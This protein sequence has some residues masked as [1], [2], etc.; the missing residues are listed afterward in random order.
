VRNFSV[1]AALFAVVLPGT[2][3]AAD[4]V[5]GGDAVMVSGTIALHSPVPDK[6]ALGYT[7]ITFDKPVCIKDAQGKD[8]PEEKAGS[9]AIVGSDLKLK[10]GQH[11]SLHGVLSLRVGDPQPPEKLVLTVVNKP[12]D[13]P[14]KEEKVI[15]GKDDAVA[16]QCA[17]RARKS[18]DIL[19]DRILRVVVTDNPRWGTVWR[20]DSA[21]PVPGSAPTLWR[22]VCWKDSSFVRPLQMFDKSKNIPPL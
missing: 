17:A 14:Q 20:A 16:D 7:A 15:T 12:A 2:G 18:A 4:C 13:I 21:H 5:N 6:G 11:A 8:Q 10:D 3:Y 22:T 1:S 9:I 19:G